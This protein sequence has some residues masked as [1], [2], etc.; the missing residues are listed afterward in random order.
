MDTIATL[1]FECTKQLT[2]KTLQPEL[3][4]RQ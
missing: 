2:R 3:R 1:L 4:L